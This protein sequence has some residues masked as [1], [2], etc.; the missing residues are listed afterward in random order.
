VKPTEQSAKLASTPKTGSFA[1]LSGPLRGEGSGARSGRVGALPAGCALPPPAVHP[2]TLHPHPI[3]AGLTVMTGALAPRRCAL[4]ATLALSAACA[5]LALSVASA[6]AAPPETPELEVLERHATT[7]F[8]RGVLNPAK[9][10]EGGTYEFL[11]KASGTE[12]EGGGKAPLT[13]GF[14]LGLEHEEFFEEL[15]PLE[16][17]TEYSVCLLAENTSGEKTVSAPVTFK[18]LLPPETP[19]TLKAEPVGGTSATLRGVLNPN[20]PGE[21]GH[22]VFR[23]RPS[24]SECEGFEGTDTFTSEQHESSGGQHEAAQAEVTGLLPT[25]TYTFCLLAE[26]GAGEHALG[27]PQTFTTSVAPPAV[28]EE[29]IA[30]VTATEAT[31]S[32]QIQPGGQP[33]TYQVEY[34]PGKRTPEQA[35]AASSTPVGVQQKLTGLQP[36]TEYHVRFTV[37]NASGPAEGALV[38]FTTSA[39]Q[40]AIALGLPDNRAYERVSSGNAEV[41]G[42][43]RGGAAEEDTLSLQPF[44]AAADGEAVGYVAEPPSEEGSGVTGKDLGNEWLGARA[45]AGW[46]ASD[47]T[48]PTETESF[49]AWT[50][51]LGMAIFTATD[52][53]PLNPPLTPEVAAN[54]SLQGCNVLYAQTAGRVN[55]ALFD[56]TTTPGFCGGEPPEI[57]FAGASSGAAPRLL[58][59]TPAALS[60]EAEPAGGEASS[61]LYYTQSG[62]LHSVN[63]LAGKPDPNATFGAPPLSEEAPDFNNVVS[64][65]GS[66]IFWTD[67]N[68]EH[69]YVR[70]SDTRNVQV[71]GAH[72]ARYWTATRPN[73]RY[74][75]YTEEGQLWRFDAQ[76]GSRQQ[77]AG[78]GA[79]GVVGVNETGEEGA[80]VYFV[81]SSVLASNENA[82]KETATEGEPNLYLHHGGTTSFIA[83]LSP[84][85]NEAFQE[86]PTTNSNVQLGDWRQSA[87][88]RTAIVSSDGS[89]LAFLSRKSFTGYDNVEPFQGRELESV[90]VPEL[91]SYDAG[92]VAITCAS[93]NPSGE[94]PIKLP[95]IDTLL[96]RINL[97]GGAYV[98][99][100]LSPTYMPRWMSANG[101]RL[102]FDTPEPLVPQDTNGRQDVYE[103]ERSGAGSCRRSAGCIYLLSG[104]TVPDASFLVDADETGKNVFFVDRGQLVPQDRDGKMDLYD[105]R[106][107]GG[108]PESALACTGTG[109]QGVPPAPP[110]FATPASAT[111]NGAGNLPPSP[112]PR[113]PTAAQIR[114]KRLATALKA[115]RAKR[116]RHKR[117]LCEAQAHK[118]YGA[119]HKAKRS[120]RARK[121]NHRGRGSR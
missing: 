73:G 115:C 33:A 99:V 58:F 21:A 91:F 56:T 47:I 52:M 110:S 119:G 19:E 106:E 103:W 40:G 23:Y 74:V 97:P 10:G 43:H 96:N 9:E 61:N 31:L 41:Y 32:A 109:C 81:A 75:Y 13:P 84:E 66:R 86:P 112:A 118:R 70:E 60:A 24:A 77:L 39:S 28:T 29:S 111:F 18:T 108:F 14:S 48:P 67:L 104:G 1:M 35:L 87:G 4:I 65:D 55:H 20:A 7:A 76:E 90:P 113:R 93:C 44:R 95:N 105:A 85:D 72:P 62:A 16:P 2:T 26:N 100:S 53:P 79:L 101:D 120:S 50:S 49:K 46:S 63:V 117:A 98:P 45:P 88:Y 5:L 57:L 107:G 37:H 64:A 36:A 114:A 83:T 116:N 80:Y 102:F 94:P 34:E 92:T 42:P 22:Y 69:I 3:P 12:C 78:E 59:Q 11:F 54:P 30:G 6:L 27:P 121:A 17:A 25:T 38:S 8:V 51:D 71:S 68:T 15:S 82:N 89:R